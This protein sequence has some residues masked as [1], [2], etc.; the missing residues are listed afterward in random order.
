MKVVVIGAGLSGLAA[1]KRLQERGHEV[2]VLETLDRPGGRCKTLRQDGFIV[3]TCTE[4]ATA[5]YRRWLELARSVDLEKDIVKPPMVM[6]MLRKGRIINVDL[7]N[8]LSLPFTPLLSWR[9]KLKF[10][11]GVFSLR[12]AIFSMPSNLLDATALDDPAMTAEDLVLK[13]F[14]P[15]VAEYVM[16]PL[17]RMIG[18]TKMHEVSSLIVPYSLSDF[19][20]L[21]SLRGGL[22]RLPKA[23]AAKLN[24]RYQTAVKQI[25]SNA[26]DVTIEYVDA[27]G[28]GGTLSADKCLITA[29]YDDAERMYPRLADIGD[30]YGRKLQFMRLVD[31]KLA[32]SKRPDSKAATVWVPFSEDPELNFISLSHNK[33]PDRAPAGHS[34]FS[35]YTEHAEYDRMAAMSDEQLVAWACKTTEKLFPELKGHFLFHYLGR[36]P[37]TCGFPDPGFFH[38]TSKLWDNIGRE[39]RVHL[40]GEIFNYGTM[41]AAVAFGERAADRLVGA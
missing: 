3:D 4:L 22:D 19:S 8:P 34:L 36:Q 27:D 39:P 11:R 13:A 24:I 20:S 33:S 25:R 35:L 10:A 5:S 7:G 15:E 12:K 17:I 28:S 1:A 18:G 2:Q 31:I 38:R 14:G 32:Y 6:G 26:A 40:G 37:R 23:V 30:N 21:I 16:E 41:E 9:A 29:Q